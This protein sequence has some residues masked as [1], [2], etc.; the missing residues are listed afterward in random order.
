MTAMTTERHAFELPTGQLNIEVHEQNWPFDKC[1]GVGA[2]QNPKRGFLFVSKLLGKHIP[3][4][5]SAMREAHHELAAKVMPMLDHEPTLF[6]AM[7][8]TATGLGHG[9]YEAALEQGGDNHPWIFCTTTRYRIEG[10]ERI[11]FTEDHSHATDQWLH[12][13]KTDVAL[14]NIRTLVLVDDEISTGKTMLNLESSL[15]AKLPSLEK[16]LWVT[17]TCLANETAR[18]CAYLLKGRFDF[19]AGILGKMPGNAVGNE[20]DVTA[21]LSTN[22]GRVGVQ[23]KVTL[24]QACMGTLIRHA[25]ASPSPKPVLVLGQG[26][27]M[28][29]AYRVGEMLEQLDVDCKVQSTTRSPIMVYGAIGCALSVPDPMGTEVN[30]YVYNL[31]PEE[32]SHIF[33]V[34]ETQ[35]SPESRALA[36]QLGNASVLAVDF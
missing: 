1:M 26:E 35:N 24:G 19:V 23:G 14:E 21:K 6:V 12:M 31:N 10:H 27:F 16:V 7:A 30:H 32:Y 4:A 36:H 15:K 18:P 3:V 22:W 9:V 33:V 11:D 29:A 20:K 8:E 25:M 17:L 28:H 2:R 5:P 34:A 13:P